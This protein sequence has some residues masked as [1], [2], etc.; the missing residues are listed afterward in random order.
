MTAE[1]I[2]L[3][4]TRSGAPWSARASRRRRHQVLGRT[5]AAD[6]PVHHLWASLVDVLGAIAGVSLVVGGIGIMNIML[7]TVTE[8][9]QEIG[10]RRALGAK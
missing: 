1:L 9:T 3:P 7:A 4:S 6:S 2:S 8:R 10:I 5:P